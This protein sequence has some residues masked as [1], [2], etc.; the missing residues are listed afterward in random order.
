MN[1]KYSDWMDKNRLHFPSLILSV[2]HPI[3][4]SRLESHVAFFQLKELAS[5]FR[6]VLAKAVAIEA[7]RPDHRQNVRET[8]ARDLLSKDPE[9]VI[10]VSV[11]CLEVFDGDVVF[12][13]PA[14]FGNQSR[15]SEMQFFASTLDKIKKVNKEM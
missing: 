2:M 14:S 6:L 15:F 3:S 5:G 7:L 13:N 12:V 4:K 8:L 11:F 1:S 10:V 9:Q